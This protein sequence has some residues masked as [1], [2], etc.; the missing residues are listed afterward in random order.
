DE[1]LA[2]PTE[3]SVRLALRTQQVIAYES[4]VADT[5]DPLC[6]SYFVE[7]LT[8][9]IENRVREYLEKIDGLGGAV[10]AIEKQF[11][12]TE[13]MRSAYEYQKAIEEKEKIIVGVN[14][15]QTEEEAPATILRIDES[16]RTKQMER[17]RSVRQSRDS[18]AVS[19]ALNE[20][21]R[22]AETNEN[23][24]P[25][26]LAAVEGYATVGEISDTLRKVWGEY[27]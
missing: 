8:N 14:E 16:I 1:A 13:I 15:F 19:R 11:Y 3:E 4:G 7:S 21:A 18:A 2:L 23:V 6:G 26:I 20:L 27:A 17:L 5:I 10:K 9:E 25:S 24:I 22:A 12:Q